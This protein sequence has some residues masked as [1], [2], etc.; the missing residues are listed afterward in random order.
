MSAHVSGSQQIGWEVSSF[1]W[2]LVAGASALWGQQFCRPSSTK[3]QGKSTAKKKPGRGDSRSL[4]GTVMDDS[5]EAKFS[6]ELENR[7]GNCKFASHLNG[8]RVSLS[9][10]LIGGR[11]EGKAYALG[12]D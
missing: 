7:S 8:G 10:K 9:K 11:F 1:Q 6:R 4:P 2:S 12:R 5:A 3:S